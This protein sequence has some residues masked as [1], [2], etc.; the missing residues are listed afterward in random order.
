MQVS[1]LLLFILTKKAKATLLISINFF[2]PPIGTTVDVSPE[3]LVLVDILAWVG[4]PITL[5][6][7][8]TATVEEVEGLGKGVGVGLGVKAAALEDV[9]TTV[10]KDVVKAREVGA[11]VSNTEQP[12]PVPQ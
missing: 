4:P 10:G 9:L 2:A 5:V 6:I 12:K 11:E 1:I 8:F 7:P 3:E